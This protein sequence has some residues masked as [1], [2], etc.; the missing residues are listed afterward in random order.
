MSGGRRG[1]DEETALLQ[2]SSVQ[3]PS[4]KP[5]R[6]RTFITA[7]V[8]VFLLI[9]AGAYS[10]RVSS[11]ARLDSYGGAMA[12]GQH[13]FHV[14]EDPTT[15]LTGVYGLDAA[16]NYRLFG[17]GEYMYNVSGSMW[18]YLN[19][20]DTANTNDEDFIKTR[21]AV[22]YLE[23]R[24]TCVHMEE[25]YLNFMHAMFEGK[26]PSKSTQKFLEDNYK[27][28]SQQAN[29]R[30]RT[31]DYWLAVK[32]VLSQLEGILEGLQ[33]GCPCK[34][35]CSA[36][37]NLRSLKNPT[38]LHLL[39]LNADGDLY[40]ITEKF[41]EVSQRRRQR[42]LKM[43]ET[44]HR[45]LQSGPTH[46]EDSNSF[47]SSVGESGEANSMEPQGRRG[48]NHCSALIKLLPG[49]A[50]VLFGHDTWYV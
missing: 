36:S 3:P 22:G 23:G 50:D 41:T 1:P 18:N 8:V 11:S 27:W 26:L 43:T 39:L 35:K 10:Y 5:P 24:L 30:Y 13:P 45:R 32:G 6:Q 21:R 48:E 2:G 29:A 34:G 40:Q 44:L 49:N 4:P 37:T 9:S 42:R 16:G 28:V 25:Y 47:K 38:I 14:E 33:S 19:V 7:L 20:E 46:S 12:D 17:R 31:D 15:G